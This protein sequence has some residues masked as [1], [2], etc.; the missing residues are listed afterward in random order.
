MKC[1]LLLLLV[2]VLGGC[3]RASERLAADLR[4][5]D[6]KTQ[7]AAIRKLILTPL[8]TDEVVIALREAGQSEDVE[9]RT[10]AVTALGEVAAESE[11]AVDALVAAL[12]DP[13]RTIQFAAATA[14]LEID[15][16]SEPPREVVLSEIKRVNPHAM[17]LVAE[18][19]A[20]ATWAAPALRQVLSH[21]D[22][23]VRELAR[24]AL[25][26]IGEE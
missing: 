21:R 19:G 4:S 22:K 14:L 3:D 7:K 20:E 11:L 10:L 24:L 9:V 1:G 16:T 17:I 8:G 15:K 6:L 18:M 25:S 13:K 12:Q 26:R 5:G 2:L 23:S